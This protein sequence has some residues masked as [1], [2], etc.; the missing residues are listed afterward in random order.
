[1]DLQLSGR[2]LEDFFYRIYP[3][4]IGLDLI[5]AW[6]MDSVGERA[7]EYNYISTCRRISSI[8]LLH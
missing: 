7:F 3:F 6:R 5:N 8:H 1:M 2:R 4:V